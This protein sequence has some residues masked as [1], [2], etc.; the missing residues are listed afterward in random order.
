M[1]RIFAM[2]ALSLISLPFAGT[3]AHAF[4]RGL[5]HVENGQFLNCSYSDNGYEEHWGGHESCSDCLSHHAA[6]TESCD[7]SVQVCTA[8][9][10]PRPTE[11]GHR[12][13]EPN[14]PA[15]QLVSIVGISAE[16]DSEARTNAM[17][18]CAQGGYYEC[19]VD[20]CRSERQ[21]VSIRDCS[22]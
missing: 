22:R 7:K 19:R 2:I 3:E 10:S 1:T 12:P 17:V 15:V 18:A 21:N 8:L 11:I 20:S 13:G 4:S 9:G 5:G 6:C 16:S 14:P